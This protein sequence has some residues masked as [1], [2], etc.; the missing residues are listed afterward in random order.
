[1][2]H[3]TDQLSSRRLDRTGRALLCAGTFVLGALAVLFGL[4]AAWFMSYFSDG[5]AERGLVAMVDAWPA[6]VV[7]LVLI[8]IVIV[9]L[10]RVV[11]G[12]S[13]ALLLGCLAG[14]MVALAGVWLLLA[15][16]HDVF[17]AMLLVAA[18]AGAAAM[19]AGAAAQLVA[20]SVSRP[21]AE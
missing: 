5:S 12:G 1:M 14:L 9:A 2:E 13:T 16:G 3:H 6:W 7:T 17:R 21:S 18:V 20:R 4:V 8:A 19:A 15:G 11:R 10:T